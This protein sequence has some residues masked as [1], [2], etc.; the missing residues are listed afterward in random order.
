MKGTITLDGRE[1]QL[2]MSSDTLRVYREMF[3]RDLLFD[4]AKLK[5]GVDLEVLEN[6]TYVAAE[7]CDP[8]MPPLHEWLKGLRPMAIMNAA[9]EVLNLWLG[10]E[11][12]TTTR[13]KKVDQ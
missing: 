5:N 7:A 10:N 12:T 9:D 2:D 6:L 4:M 3:Q 8:E 11:T 1:V 13:K